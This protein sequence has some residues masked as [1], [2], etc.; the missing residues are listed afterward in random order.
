MDSKYLINAEFTPDKI[1][2]VGENEIFV[3]GS[4]LAG[5]HLGGAA[6]AAVQRFGAVM[7]QGEGRQ[8]NSY[9]IPTMQG[10]VETIRPYVDR[11]I[12]FAIQHPEL[13]FY[14]TKIGCGIAGFK[15][16]EIAPL[17][18]NALSVD[19]I[20]LPKEF[21]E[22]I[23]KN[24]ALCHNDVITHSYGV[25]RTFADL[26]IA[27]NEESPFTTPEEA[28]GYLGGYFGRFQKSGDEVAFMAVRAFWC[29]I[30]DGEMFTDGKLNVGLL[31]KKIFN[32][33]N[34]AGA[35]D[36]AYL[37]YCKEKICNA[38]ATFNEF[39]RY[40]NGQDIIDD[41]SSAK[42]TAFSHC[43]VNDPY[44]LISPLKSGN[45]YPLQ[46]FSIFIHDNWHK[47]APNGKL[48]ANL[49]NEYMFNKHERGI[50]K[51]G[52]DAVIRHDYEQDGPCHSEVFFPKQVGRGPI[53]VDHG[54][55]R[56]V[57]SCGEGKGPNAMPNYLEATMAMTLLEKD[58]QY[59]QVGG[60]FLPKHDITLPVYDDFRGKLH[61][62]DADEKRRFIDSVRLR[63]SDC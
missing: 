56:F 20:R 53:Y 28:L 4:N 15:I 5:R 36:K 1:S 57:R 14:V 37:L 32:F 30:N 40:T 18:C 54:K 44:Y 21:V 41:L 33:D 7:G 13:I 50:R 51:Y 61:F 16:E 10:G 8:G 29:I 9:A 43:G 38:V 60:Y 42:L 35:L 26:I 47:I 25:T 39:R 52:L 55:G 11:F 48:D 46:F 23:E 2:A 12:G 58:P 31:R 24:L 62:T 6:R 22:T 3:F 59:E 27:R 45:G 63:M 34:Y 17:F 49:L 19:N